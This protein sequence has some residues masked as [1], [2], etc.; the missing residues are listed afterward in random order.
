MVT[1]Q[2][3]L[4]N[5][6]KLP[7]GKPACPGHSTVGRYTRVSINSMGLL[8][9][10]PFKW[11]KQVASD[12]GGTRNGLIV[13]YPKGIE[14]KN[15]LRTQFTHAIDIA[16]TVLEVA[17]L[18][19]P[20]VVNGV[21]QIPIEGTSFAYS[22]N[23]AHAAERHTIQYFEMFGNRAIYNNGWFART[24]HRAPWQTTNLPPLETDVWELYL[25]TADFSLTNNL[26]EKYPGKLKQME[27]L[28]MWQ[29]QKHH[30]LPIDDRTIQRT[31]AALA[32]RPDLLGDRTSLTL[33]QG[34]EGM[35][36]NTFINIKNRSFSITAEIDIP[37]GGANGAILSQGGRLV[38][39]H[40]T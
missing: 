29:A 19:E 25:V 5:G 27:S 36:E 13:Q 18:P 37:E 15:E 32:G 24:I 30:A 16:P 23:D 1:A 38:A 20:K 3:L 2:V 17:G 6:M 4:A 28:F 34:M 11:T 14:E 26:A 9:R 8:V 40:S 33:Y 10:R 35:M 12:F 31:N 21:P 7:L 22:F 39:G